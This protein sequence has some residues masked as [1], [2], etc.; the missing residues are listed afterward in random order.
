MLQIAVLQSWHA[1]TIWLGADTASDR[2]AK[3]GSL[4]RLNKQMNLT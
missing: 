3:I 2:L 1:C 4:K